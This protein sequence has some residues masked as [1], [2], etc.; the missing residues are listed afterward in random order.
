MDEKRALVIESIRHAQLSWIPFSVHH[1]PDP[2]HDLF[3]DQDGA[4]GDEAVVQNLT[5]PLE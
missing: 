2:G 3:G 4:A 1:H 5:F